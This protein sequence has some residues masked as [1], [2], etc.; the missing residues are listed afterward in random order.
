MNR[1]NFG[2]VV[3]NGMQILSVGATTGS[4]VLG[5]ANKTLNNQDSEMRQAKLDNLNAKTDNLKLKND[6]IKQKQQT[7]SIDDIM[8]FAYKDNSSQIQDIKT[9]LYNDNEF[10][11]N[12]RQSLDNIEPLD[13][14]I[15][16]VTGEDD[17]AN[18]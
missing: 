3:T 4:R 6:S 11:Y 12:W 5:A 15:K 1:A 13:K 17:N 14:L 10:L 18:A 2:N 7:A 16:N 9:K 8:N